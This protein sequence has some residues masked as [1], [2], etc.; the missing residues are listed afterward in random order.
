MP[1]EHYDEFI[2]EAFINP[3]RSVL[4]VDDD[5]PTYDDILKDR[6]FVGGDGKAWRRRRA[7]FASVID[8]FRQG[9]RPLLVDIHDGSNVTAQQDIATA[10]HLHQ[11]DLLVL[12]FALDKDNPNDGTRA[13]EILRKLMSNVH[14]N[15]VVIYTKEDLEVVFDEVRWGLIGPSAD[16]LS[17]DESNMAVN[18]IEDGE[19]RYEGFERDLSDAIGPDQYFYS[20]LN[21]RHFLRTVGKKE[22]PY[23]PFSIH[24]DRLGWNI[25]Q[26]RIVV[27]YLLKRL[28]TQNAVT[29]DPAIRFE[30]LQWSREAPTWI[31]SESAFVALS[32]KRKDE[33]N[34]LC[35][36]RAALVDWSPRPSQLFLTKLRAEID[37]YGV[38][39]QQDVL[40]N[41][42]AL[43]YWYFRLL[44]GNHD[45]DLRWRVLETVSRHTER[46]L[47]S[48][49][50]RVEQF[51]SSLI[52]AEIVAGS[53]I[54]ICK[55]HFGV[56]L[57]KNEDM[58]LATLEHNAFVCS[59]EPAGSHLTIGHVFFMDDKYWLC[60]SPACDMVPSQM[61]QWRTEA[62]GE[63]LPFIGINLHEV[64]VN[65][66]P[67]EIHSNRF[68]FLR[69]NGQ[70]K[71]FCFNE[72]SGNEATPQWHI[73]YAQER[74]RFSEGFRFEVAYI[75][76]HETGLASTRLSAVVISQLRY[77]YALNLI[78]KLGVSLTRVGLDFAG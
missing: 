15:L 74:G 23:T 1:G 50:P 64:S 54:D 69:I 73:L 25:E 67:K 28:E 4:I 44:K 11:C 20:R 78:Q 30:D 21:Q 46:L 37:E 72:V 13:I 76:V 39:A 57:E 52:A 7:Q 3:I 6:D 41:L 59:K 42:H 26:R 70:L 45:D 10:E 32:S 68:L 58:T 77:E 14:F 17:T 8:G 35:A 12:D 18:L 31:K 27:R 62:F 16:Q 40:G 60:L 49:L 24:A 36:L 33:D 56:D 66:I 5:F 19:Y 63:H 75:S 38:A 47:S 61:S 71:G 51:A 48:I 55:D 9:P 53:P 65:K 29:N 34:V 22:P 43:A 2:E